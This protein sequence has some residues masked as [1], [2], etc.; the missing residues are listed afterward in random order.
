MERQQLTIEQGIRLKKGMCTEESTKTII[1]G[2]SSQQT[3][4][5]VSDS[6]FESIIECHHHNK[7]DND[8]E[9]G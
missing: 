6:L 9:S 3:S 2:A 7:T 5:S 1:F 8:P 4:C